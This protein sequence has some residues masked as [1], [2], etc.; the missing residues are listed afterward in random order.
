[1]ITVI[2]HDHHSCIWVGRKN[3][4][5]QKGREHSIIAIANVPIIV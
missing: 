4:V 5:F 3:E 1:M 2:A